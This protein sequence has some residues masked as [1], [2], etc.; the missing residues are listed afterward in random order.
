MQEFHMGMAIPIL[1][2]AFRF[3]GAAGSTFSATPAAPRVGKGRQRSA[4]RDGLIKGTPTF[5]FVV[6]VENIN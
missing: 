6:V 4:I 3:T 5:S 2:L 1:G